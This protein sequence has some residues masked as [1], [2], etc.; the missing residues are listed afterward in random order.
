MALGN[1][2]HHIHGL[3]SAINVMHIYL[4][5]NMESRPLILH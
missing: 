1:A 5:K 3:S 4:D 2:I